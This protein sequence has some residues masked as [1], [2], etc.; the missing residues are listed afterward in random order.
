M[1]A[2]FTDRLAADLWVQAVSGIPEVDDYETLNASS[3]MR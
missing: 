1:E 2:A 3:P